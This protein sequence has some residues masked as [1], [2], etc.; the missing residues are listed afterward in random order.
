MH[1]FT[2]F[3]VIYDLQNAPDGTVFGILNVIDRKSQLFLHVDRQIK[4]H[5]DPAG[6]EYALFFNVAHELRRDPV[7]YRAYLLGD[8]VDRINDGDTYGK[9]RYPVGFRQAAQR[10]DAEYRLF[11]TRPVDHEGQI[12]LQMLSCLHSNADVEFSPYHGCDIR[13]ER[14]SS[15]LQ[16]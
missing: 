2:Q 13:I 11:Q 10:M 12:V 3:F 14:L 6:K 5:G 4:D 15:D 16:R 1:Q 8:P 9:R 7:K